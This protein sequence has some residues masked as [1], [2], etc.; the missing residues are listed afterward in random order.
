MRVGLLVAFAG[1]NCGGPEVFERQVVHAMSSIAPQHEYHLYCLDHRAKAVIG[2]EER[3]EYHLLRPSYRAISMLTT[4]PVALARTQPDV[5]HALSVPPPF[6]PTNTIMAIQ[7]SSLIRR[8]EYFPPLIRMRLR[9]LLHRAVPKAAAVVCP[10]EHVRDVV[11]ETFDVPAGRFHVIHPGV[12]PIFRPSS[13]SERAECLERHGIRHPY[14]LFSG[15][16]EQRKNMVRIIEAFAQFKRESRT[17]HRLVFTGGRSWGAREVNQTIRKLGIED[18]ILDA[19]KTSLDELPYL[20]GGADALVYA[21]LWEGF[22]LPIVEAMACGTPVITSNVAAMPETA[23][24][25]ALLVD[26]HSTEEIAGAMHRVTTDAALRS[27]MRAGG[28][29]RVRQFG[30]DD[31]AR[32]TLN[33]YEAVARRSYPAP[34]APSKRYIGVNE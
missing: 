34:A 10:S 23:G 12:S 5:F 6:F 4:L 13:A 31:T 24:G 27:R 11:Q 18:S 7:C 21:S 16:W 25:N 14:F 20:Y 22:G 17:E 3:V 28:L 30:W 32:K 9:F 2:I 33:L 29:E 19:G 26:P 1:R 8:P 15:R